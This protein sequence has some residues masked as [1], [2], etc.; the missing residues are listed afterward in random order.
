[1]D[2]R[3]S[4]VT[5]DRELTPYEAEVGLAMTA[6]RDAALHLRDVLGRDV[7][8]YE[9]GMATVRAGKTM[10]ILVPPGIHT[11]LEGPPLFGWSSIASGA[12]ER[13]V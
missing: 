9:G 7:T 13:S 8:G 10:E 3:G 6:R 5:L 12:L 2:R 11:S 4:T 1:M